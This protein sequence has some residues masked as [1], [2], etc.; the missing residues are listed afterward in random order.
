MAKVTR[1]AIQAIA[2]PE[3]I[4][5]GEDYYESGAVV[6]LG[7]R[8]N[9]LQAEAQ[10]SDDEPYRVTLTLGPRGSVADYSCTCPYDWG[11]ACKHVVAT[12]LACQREP[13]QVEERLPLPMLL[14]DL[15]AGQLRQ[16]L[17]N[18]AGRLP[19]VTEAIE[20]AVG[21][22]RR[23]PKAQGREK[24]VG[25]PHRQGRRPGRPK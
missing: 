22:L 23:R 10:G 4:E 13:Q 17:L 5:R 12:L 14:A 16:L 20:A 25:T 6:S 7:R 3:V 15:D 24:G 18:L 8:G 9:Q 19:A 21:E 2:S 11:G 1:A